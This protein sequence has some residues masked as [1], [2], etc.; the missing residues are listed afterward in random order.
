MS[1]FLKSAMNSASDRV[2]W[3]M[4]QRVDCETDSGEVIAV[5]GAFF[6][7][8]MRLSPVCAHKLCHLQSLA[9]AAQAVR[10]SASSNTSTGTS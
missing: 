10:A 5:R 3:P 2:E 6:C 1:W 7:G 9:L 4:V 8:F